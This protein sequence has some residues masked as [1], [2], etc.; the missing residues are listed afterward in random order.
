MF[1]LKNKIINSFSDTYQEARKKFVSTAKSLSNLFLSI[2]H[3]KMGPD[4]IH[5]YTDVAYIGRED[6]D[7][8]I[9]ISSGLH[10]LEGFCG[11]GC[12][13]FLLNE[14]G[15]FVTA[16]RKNIGF[17]LIHSLNPY[18]FAWLRRVNEDN[19]DLNRNFINFYNSL[20]S[21]PEYDELAELIVPKNWET[22]KDEIYK[23]VDSCQAIWCGQYNNPTGIFYGGNNIT[24]SNRIFFRI[25]KDIPQKVNDIFFFDIH[26]GIGEWGKIHIVKSF[27]NEK[28]ANQVNIIYGISLENINTQK[29][30][31]IS[32][33]ICNGITSYFPDRNVIPICLECGTL[34]F[35]IV[36][37][38]IRS[39][40]WLHSYGNLDSKIAKLIKSDI[41]NA[42]Y[43]NHRAWKTGV[44]EQFID[45]IEKSVYYLINK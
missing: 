2:K 29:I 10:G 16:T 5:L 11:S 13:I 27:L 32:G 43:Q 20:P 15:R 21:N 30:H 39:D 19:V 7:K 36:F 40:A 1:F 25:L 12:Q 23:K 44:C 34:D 31:K 42:F 4:N 41:K 17:L 26:T 28:H 9:I 6:I 37:D 3:P 18:G 8:L 45:N 22:Q 24:W 14:F 38:A 33:D 35:K